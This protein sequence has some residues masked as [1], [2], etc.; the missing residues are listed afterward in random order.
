MLNRATKTFRKIKRELGKL[1]EEPLERHA[2]K[3]GEDLRA[4]QVEAT[5]KG[6]D[7]RAVL[8]REQAAETGV[9]YSGAIDPKRTSIWDR[10]TKKFQ[11][12][13]HPSSTESK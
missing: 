9:F 13:W 12:G 7:K 2:R 8:V 10:T 1:T 5:K 3:I 6:D 11:E 4:Q